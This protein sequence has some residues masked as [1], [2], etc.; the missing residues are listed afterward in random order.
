M[1]ECQFARPDRADEPCCGSVREIRG[2][3]PDGQRVTA[4]ACE[5]HACRWTIEAPAP[6]EM[7]A[8][9]HDGKLRNFFPS[10]RQC[11]MCSAT[12]PVVRVRVTQDDDGAFWAW[13]S[14]ERKTFSYTNSNRHGV[15]VCFTYGSKAAEEHGEGKVVRVRVDVLREATKEELR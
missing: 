13:W 9:R 14:N 11:R 12:D 2:T 1:S 5:G 3:D 10:I 4:Q 15:E 7:W 8:L 6:V